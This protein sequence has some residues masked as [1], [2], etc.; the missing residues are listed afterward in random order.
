MKIEKC[1]DFL[2]I[3][4]VT[5]TYKAKDMNDKQNF[6]PGNTLS[7]LRKVLKNFIYSQINT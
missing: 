1:P 3:V 2:K 4:E 6:R 5:P 7:N